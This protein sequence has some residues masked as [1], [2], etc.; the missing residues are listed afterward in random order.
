MVKKRFFAVLI[1]SLLI[2]L[3]L[4]AVNVPSIQGRVSDY[5]KIIRDSDEREIEEYLA[6]LEQST[7]IQIAVLTMP[8]LEGEDISSFG[9]K[10]ADKWNLDNSNICS[11]K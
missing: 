8:S 7:G 9:I 6:G 11:V 1:S 3:S 5:A 2:S 4:F 10:V